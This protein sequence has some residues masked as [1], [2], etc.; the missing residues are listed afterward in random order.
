[1]LNYSIKSPLI[2]VKKRIKH[3]R[4]FRKQSI[5]EYFRDLKNWELKCKEIQRENNA[6]MA[7]IN[8]KRALVG[9][10]ILRIEPTYPKKPYL[11]KYFAYIA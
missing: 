11:R 3:I 8:A 10:P 9:D 1:M 2:P 4:E 5:K 6:K 7:K